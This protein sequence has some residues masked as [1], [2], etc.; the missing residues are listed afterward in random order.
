M[1]KVKL[2]GAVRRVNGI[3]HEYGAVVDIDKEQADRLLATGSAIGPDDPTPQDVASGNVNLESLKVEQ[4]QAIATY[5]GVDV[6][7]G[8]KKADLVG[9]IEAEG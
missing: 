1:A 4:L 7:E 3:F 6:P 9:L 5:R 2:I 8:A